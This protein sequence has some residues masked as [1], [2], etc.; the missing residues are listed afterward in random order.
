MNSARRGG[1]LINAIAGATLIV[2]LIQP[3]FSEPAASL[4]LLKA[5]LA[6]IFSLL[7]HAAAHGELRRLED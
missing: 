5:A 2:G 7:A 4:N 6:L 1:A 3:M